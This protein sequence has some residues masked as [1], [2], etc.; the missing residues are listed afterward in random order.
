MSARTG[1]LDSLA[2]ARIAVFTALATAITMIPAFSVIGVEGAS[3]TLGA[4]VPAILGVMLTPHEA[5]VSAIL[6]GVLATII[7]PPGIFGP[8]SPLPLI[9]G[10]IAVILVYRFGFKGLIGYLALHLGLIASFIAVSGEAY[11][12]EYPLYPWFHLL[13]VI[14]VLLLSL[15]RGQP[16]LLLV[17]SIAG[18]LVDHITGSLIAQVYFPLIAGY[19]IPGKIW[20]AVTWIYPIERTILIAIAYAVLMILYKVGVPAPWAKK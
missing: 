14:I 11:F 2:I 17:A 20:A 19:T 9:I 3:I 6:A 15:K 1:I 12:N 8:L 5:I 4:I 7:P 10:T 13:G 16:A 18:I